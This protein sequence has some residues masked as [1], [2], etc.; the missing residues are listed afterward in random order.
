MTHWSRPSGASRGW[1]AHAPRRILERVTTAIA[2]QFEQDRAREPLP[3]TRPTLGALERLPGG[4]LLGLVALVYLALAQYVIS[5][6]DPVQLGAGF[7]P[8]AGVSL[9]LLLLLPTRRWPWVLAGIALGEFGGDLLRGYPLG[10]TVLWT[11][12]NVVEPLVG[13]TLVRRFSSRGGD[14]APAR[15]LVGFLVLAV[16]AGPLVGATIGSLGSILFVGSSPSQVWPMYL[17]GD[18]LGVLVMA[19]L[20]LTWAI[21]SPRRSRTEFGAL[22]GTSLLVAFVV[23][24]N[25]S[26]SWDLTLPYLTAPLFT[27]AA[28]RFGLRG[29]AIVAVLVANI[30]NWSTANGY[31]PFA[32]A[33]GTEHAVTLLQVFLLIS[34]TSSFMLA[35]V[36]RDLSQTNEVRAQLASHNVALQAAID[37]VRTSQL[38]IRKLEGILP[39]CMGCKAVRSDDDQRWEPLD[40]YL[41][42]SASVSLS[43]GYCPP[44]AAAALA[45]ID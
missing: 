2:A 34:L 17:V 28:L 20:L 32:I 35:S 38:Y 42:R 44:C 14:L 33:G 18:A 26:G 41:A 43:H 5:L 21:P 11:I 30:A 29:T 40:L 10:A 1:H 12:G 27:W 8:A 23:F 25:W 37:E 24:R 45:A 31:G 15:R 22:L 16:I 6:N 3:A 39:I 19:P 4:L 7:W 36:A 13:A 9:A